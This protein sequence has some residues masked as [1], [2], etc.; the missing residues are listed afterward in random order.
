M[1]S[2]RNSGGDLEVDCYSGFKGDERPVRFRIG[3]AVFPIDAV[4]DH[5]R[6]PEDDCFQV[7]A[8]GGIYVLRHHLDLDTWSIEPRPARAPHKGSA[9]KLALSAAPPN[10]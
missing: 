9:M 3:G 2:F 1:H 5:W 6:T 4:L 8:A 10:P 7:R